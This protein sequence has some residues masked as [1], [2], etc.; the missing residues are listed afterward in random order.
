MSKIQRLSDISIGYNFH[1]LEA[2][3][4]HG[5]SSVPKQLGSIVKTWVW[6]G[7]FPL[8][9]SAATSIGTE[10]EHMSVT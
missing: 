4:K 1:H 6:R 5:D 8:N 7:E 3:K 9:S 2:F 10:R